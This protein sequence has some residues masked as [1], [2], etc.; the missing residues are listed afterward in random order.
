MAAE[1]GGS[2]MG[3]S[4]R[5]S[6]FVGGRLSGGAARLAGRAWYVIAAAGALAL[7]PASAASA[8]TPLA[9]GKKHDRNVGQVVIGLVV[10][11]VILVLLFLV[12]RVVRRRLRG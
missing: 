2:A 10:V 12:F 6:R 7:V 1:H 8:A 5:I 9:A 4:G 11:V 3:W